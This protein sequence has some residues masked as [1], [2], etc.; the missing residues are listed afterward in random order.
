LYNKQQS[1]AIQE[2][3]DEDYSRFRRRS[4]LLR[5]IAALLVLGFLLLALP[6]VG[7]LITSRPQ[8]SQDPALNHDPIAALARPAIVVIE[9]QS[10]A[11]LGM[12]IKKGTGFNID[13]NGLIITNQHVLSGAETVSISFVDGRRY[14]SNRWLQAGDVDIAVIDI[15]GHDLPTLD[16]NFNSVLQPGQQVTVIGNPLNME[17]LIQKG[18]LADFTAPAQ[19][20][21]LAYIE[22]LVTAAPGLSGSP[23][24]DEEGRVVAVVYAARKKT[25]DN[26]TA[27]AIPVKTIYDALSQALGRLGNR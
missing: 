18:L 4:P 11:G 6:H 7:Q 9:A 17:R 8:L 1:P 13:R 16:L 19:G 15:Q 22:V 24:V 12:Q 14:Y 10:T 26:N 21:K 5:G 2:H 25:E 3:P 23:V 27:L 20:G